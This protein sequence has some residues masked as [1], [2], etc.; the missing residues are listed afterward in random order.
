MSRCK[1]TSQL[2][3]VEVHRCSVAIC[4]WYLVRREECINSVCG[5][6]NFTAAAGER[7]PASAIV[8]KCQLDHYTEMVV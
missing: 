7:N 4:I 5:P 8:A 3:V 1:S 2:V 6:T